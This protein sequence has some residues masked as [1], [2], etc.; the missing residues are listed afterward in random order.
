MAVLRDV[1]CTI[2]YSGFHTAAFTLPFAANAEDEYSARFD[3][4]MSD[5]YSAMSLENQVTGLPIDMVESKSKS[6]PVAKSEGQ[7][8]DAQVFENSST[9][10][11][12]SAAA[13]FGVTKERNIQFIY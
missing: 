3:M 5:V 9:L 7:N 13:A 4:Q 6:L 10:S 1:C 2:A 11:V 8:F 12:K